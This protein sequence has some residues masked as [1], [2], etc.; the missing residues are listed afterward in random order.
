MVNAGDVQN[1]LSYTVALIV[2]LMGFILPILLLLHYLRFRH[3][4]NLN[5]V[6]RFTELYDGFKHH[7]ICR[8]YFFIFC[9]R[10]VLSAIIVVGMREAPLAA[11]L[12][13]FNFVQTLC[14][15]YAIIVRPFEDHRDNIM[16]ILNE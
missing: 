6:G 1:G 14:L 15:F 9:C 16:E 8:L 11:K 7:A 3:H 2:L 5:E 12:T 10:R 13:L 4:E